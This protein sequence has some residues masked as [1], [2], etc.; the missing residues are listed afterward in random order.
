MR[1]LFR[2]FTVFFIAANAHAAEPT[3][4]EVAVPFDHFGDR[5]ETFDLYVEFG[6]P[7][8]PAKPTVF[9][10][11]DGQQF[12]IRRGH[13]AE[14]QDRL[15]GDGINVIGIVGRGY[16]GEYTA[17]KAKVG[18]PDSDPDWQAAWRLFRS[19]QWVE[20]IELV[21]KNIL[22]DDSKIMLWGRSGG[23]FLVHEYLAAHGEHASRAFTSA[24]A[25]TPMARFAGVHPD[26]FWAEIGASDAQAQAR[27]LEV[28]QRPGTDRHSLAMAFQRQ[29]F[30]VSMDNRDAAR[31]TLLDAF[32]GNDENA[33]AAAYKDYQVTAVQRMNAS[34]AGWPI[35]IHPA[36]RRRMAH[37]ADHAAAGH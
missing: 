9:A 5:Q 10:L 25:V 36:L 19:A 32:H 21:R 23:G 4:I 1:S 28:M 14:Y 33:I 34:Q 20:D 37:P 18:A 35:R 6:A 2:Y 3:A 26:H 30:F 22:G 27:L 17:L 8:D 31:L 29:N 12:F 24:P 13:V 11:N 7:F 15:F 16:P